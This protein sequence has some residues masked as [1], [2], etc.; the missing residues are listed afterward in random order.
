MKIKTSE[1]TGVALDWAV[2]KC[3]GE[4]V[5]FC[6]GR[7]WAEDKLARQRIEWL[8]STSWEQSG[9][10]IERESIT[11]IRCDDDYKTDKEGYCTNKRIPVWAA[12]H[13]GGHSSGES[14][15]GYGEP[16]EYVYE[17]S[18]ADCKYGPTPLIA[19]MRCYVASK[20]GKV[21]EIPEEL[22]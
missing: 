2:A 11:I 17:I 14:Y 22:I 12:E 1:L 10:I 8:P 16:G 7:W 9:P 3:E 18:E 6:D 20:L 5:K 4:A 13:G 21:V 19:A 15:N